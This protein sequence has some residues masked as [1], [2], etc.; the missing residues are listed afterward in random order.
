[1]L[2]KHD[3]YTKTIKPRG[4]SISPE[5]TLKKLPREGSVEVDLLVVG[6]SSGASVSYCIPTKL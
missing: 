4:V 6:T 5:E 2:A 1:M 3:W